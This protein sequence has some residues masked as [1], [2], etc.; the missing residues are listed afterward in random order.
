L[1]PRSV[2]S[3][4]TKQ[5]RSGFPCTSIVRSEHTVRRRCGRAK[6]FFNAAVRRKLI[7]ENPF[8]DLKSNVHGNPERFAFVS[9]DD[10]A[11]VIAECPDAQW[12]RIFALSRFGGLRCP[13]EHLQLRWDDI[14]WTTNRILIS[15]PKTAH[16]VG[17]ELRVIPL[18]PDVRTHVVDS[19]AGGRTSI[20]PRRAECA[21]RSDRPGR[22]GHVPQDGVNG[23]WKR[24]LPHLRQTAT[25][26]PQ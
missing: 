2:S 15:S 24:R 19:D 13:P 14:D 11:R 22:L 7:P 6:Q 5:S 21:L 16:H 8:S 25:L 26:C 12:K 9:R 18:F 23:R 1:R 4:V 3:R 17:G 20:R 10:I